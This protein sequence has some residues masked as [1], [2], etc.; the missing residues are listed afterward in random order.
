MWIFLFFFPSLSLINKYTN[1]MEPLQVSFKLR[2]FSQYIT[3]WSA[4][5]YILASC[6]I[7][8]PMNR[9]FWKTHEHVRS[10]HQWACC[11]PFKVKVNSPKLLGLRWFCI[12]MVVYTTV[13]I[14]HTSK[15]ML[16][17]LQARLQHCMGHALPDI[18][19]GF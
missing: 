16:K 1:T 9:A 5:K 12:W 17:I 8:G 15:V 13:V 4:T 3:A 18:Q 7:F 14:S 2:S 11:L 10:C 6:S 19:A